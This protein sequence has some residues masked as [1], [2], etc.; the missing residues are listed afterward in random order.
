MIKCARRFRY[1]TV[2]F[3]GRAK[4]TDSGVKRGGH[5]SKEPVKR[6]FDADTPI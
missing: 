1:T 2:D 6:H 5:A 3:D 4:P